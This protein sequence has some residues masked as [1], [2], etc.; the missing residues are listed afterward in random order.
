[1]HQHVAFLAVDFVALALGDV[2]ADVVD[3]V[4]VGLA[5]E[6]LLERLAAGSA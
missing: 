5:A 4:E 2:V 1:V 3:Q 6:D